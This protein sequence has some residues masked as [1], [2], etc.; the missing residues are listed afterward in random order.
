MPR[1]LAALLMQ[2]PIDA[3]NQTIAT[4]DTIRSDLP[5]PVPV[6][7]V[8]QT[9]FADVDGKLQFRA[10][11]YGRDAEIWQYLE[12]EKNGSDGTAKR[13]KAGRPLRQE[14]DTERHAEGYEGPRHRGSAAALTEMF[15]GTLRR[16]IQAVQSST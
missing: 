1:Q 7:V 16:K 10:D 2:Q 15:Y 3:I 5:K 4:G 14:V 6:F 13:P 8:Y 11:V 9:A 12:S